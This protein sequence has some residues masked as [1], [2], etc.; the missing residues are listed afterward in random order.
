MTQLTPRQ[1]QVVQLLLEGNST[2]EIAQS[3]NI[4]FHTAKFHIARLLEKFEVDNRSQ[5]VVAA[6][7]TGVLSLQPLSTVITVKT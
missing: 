3:L 7:R 2:K 5:V 1:N 6:L 4:S